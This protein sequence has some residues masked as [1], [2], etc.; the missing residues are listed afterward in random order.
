MTRED[1]IE[2]AQQTGLLPRTPRLL[3]QETLLQGM[4]ERFAKLV[5]AHEREEC[6]KVCEARNAHP[7]PSGKT[8]VLHWEARECAR[9]IRARGNYEN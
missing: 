7:D 5:A 8:R 2:I 3:A 9:A 1:I 6:A 4:L